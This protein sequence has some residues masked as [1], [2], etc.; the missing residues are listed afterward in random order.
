MTKLLPK[1]RELGITVI[2]V[3]NEAESTLSRQAD[4]VLAL[5]SPVDELVAVQT[6]TGTLLV[7]A[8]LAAAVGQQLDARLEDVKRLLQI[9]PAYLE[10]CLRTD[11]TPFLS[12][13]APIYFLGRGPSLSSIYESALLMHE[14]AKEP[15]IGM[16]VAQF[17][18]GPVE[19]VSPGF[20]A[21]V[22]GTQSKTRDLDRALALDLKRMG[23][24]VQWVGPIWEEA[25]TSGLTAVSVWPDSIAECL[26]PLLEV[27]PI[28]VLAYRAAEAKNIRPGQFRFATPITLSESG[29]ESSALSSF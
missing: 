7:F 8:I 20:R 21:V 14:T 3:V 15:A 22:F 26:A 10:S 6:Y 29:F 17:R 27:I 5:N 9:L 12:R 16:S 23:A 2:G 4:L 28:Q 13:A 25:E 1:L 19:A 18:H 11:L 24:Q